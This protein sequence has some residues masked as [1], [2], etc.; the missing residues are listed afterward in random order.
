[1]RERFQSRMDFLIRVCYL[2]DL[3]SQLPVV[4]RKLSVQRGHRYRFA[5]AV[6]YLVEHLQDGR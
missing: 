1:M 4:V 3:E 6:W 5:S 2:R